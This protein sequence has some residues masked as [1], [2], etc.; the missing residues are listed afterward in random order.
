MP[1]AQTVPARSDLPPEDTWRLED[2]YPDQEAWD[3]ARR[4][5]LSRAKAFA[6]HRSHLGDSPQAL[7]SAL[8]DEDDLWL[9]LEH[10]F[11]WAFFRHDQDTADPS[12]VA[13]VQEAQAANAEV[14]E[15]TSFM[16]PQLVALPAGRIESFLDEAGELAVY[17][18]ALLEVVRRR[19]HV[20]AQDVEAALAALTPVLHAP[21]E[22]ANQLSDADLRFPDVADSE[23]VA[24]PLTHGRYPRYITSRDRELRKNTYL[25]MHR[26]YAAY[27]H[28]FGASLAANVR[29]AVSEARLRRYP[30][31]L[32]MQLDD[33]ALPVGIYDRLTDAVHGALPALHRYIH[34]RKEYLGVEAFHFYDVYP[35]LAE[36][37]AES[38][39]W[40]DA[41]ALVG[42]ALKPLGDAYGRKLEE[43]LTRRYIDW[44]ENA[45]KTSGA[46]SAG[47]YGVHPYILMSYTGQREGVF[48]L[49]HEAGHSVHSMFS[50]ERQVFRNAQ[51]RI[52][53]AEVA[54][55]TNEH[56]LMHH[57]LQHTDDPTERLVLLDRSIQNFLGTVFRQTYFAEFERGVH[58]QLAEE[59][60]LT[61]EGL[62]SAYERLIRAY[63]GDDLVVD[64]DGTLEWARIPHFYRPFY[65]FQYAT[66]YISA[67]ALSQA[68][69]EGGREAAARYTELLSAGGSDD[70]L[71]ILERSGVDL[72]HGDALEKGLGLFAALVDEIEQAG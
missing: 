65:V 28:T 22:I 31:S 39:P 58:R 63:Y 5:V 71:P 36:E 16:Q 59:G 10:V 6:R 43:L 60:S 19:E 56:L 4:D 49:A 2:L 69:L 54:S 61:A 34:W 3:A 40:T 68:I 70:P 18:H 48:T 33:S 38:I 51:Y 66:G 21:G 72:M 42:E 41:K 64:A 67:A 47:V 53:L 26:A 44:R 12:G 25:A 32:A 50:N 11:S 13:I 57:L 9:A 20:L 55:T 14:S 46:Y 37:R 1:K 7:L 45:G 15:A 52:F 27:S 62:S 35:P 24:H 8:K 17:R 30:S 29:Q 23:G